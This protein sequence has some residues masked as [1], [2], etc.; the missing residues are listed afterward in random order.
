M[1]VDP[2]SGKPLFA[3]HPP[4]YISRIFLI[5]LLLACGTEM[6][7]LVELSTWLYIPI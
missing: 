3:H 1:A 2:A 4:I 5:G 6:A 7:I